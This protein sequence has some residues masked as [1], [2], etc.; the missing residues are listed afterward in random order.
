MIRLYAALGIISIL[1]GGAYYVNELARDL[2]KAKADNVTLT[3][4]VDAQLN[5]INSLQEDFAL[6]NSANAN[7]RKTVNAQELENG[8][9]REKFN[10]QANGQ[11]RDLGAITRD[12]P[13]LINKIVNT[14]TDNVNRCF[15]LATGAPKLKG[16]KNNECKE[17]INSIAD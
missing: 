8:K 14:A 7:L 17:L 13:T 3:N 11:S 5:T 10:I 12:K 16:E 9:L 1:A 6:A 4:A 15:E 2:E